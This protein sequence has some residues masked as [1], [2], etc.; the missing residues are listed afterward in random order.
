MTPTVVALA[1]ALV[2]ATGHGAT[3]EVSTTTYVQGRTAFLEGEERT[4][5]P[6]IEAIGLNATDVGNPLVG[7]L[8]MHLSAWGQVDPFLTLGPQG[9][10]ADLDFA[11]LAGELFNRHLSLK[12]GRHFAFGGA[13]RARQ[14]DGA[15]VELHLFRGLGLSAHGGLLVVPR[16]AMAKGD[17]VLGARLFY[18]ASIDA[19]VGLGFEQVWE[20]G[21]VAWQLAG[22]DGRYVW[23][24]LTFGGHAAWALDARRFAEGD[25]AITWQPS[26]KLQASV[27]VRRTAP[28][29]FLSRNSILSVFAA[30]TRDGYGADLDWRPVRLLRLQAGYHYLRFGAESGQAGA[31]LAGEAGHEAALRAAFNLQPGLTAGLQGRWLETPGNGYVEGRLFLTWAITESLALAVDADLYRFKEPIQGHTHSYTGSASLTWQMGPRWAACLTGLAT[32]TPYFES[33][34]EGL[35]RLVYNF[36]TRQR[37]EVP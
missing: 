21:D 2:T 23:R 5:I 16:F 30:Q 34:F 11:Y 28:D 33:R 17:A 13:A 9:N 18:R 10:T 8:S 12:L 25:L 26:A 37:E 20:R 15:S 4:V 6:V 22:I 14:V 36:S 27:D 1:S 31:D 35:A 29:L 7:D 19:E 3:V 24:T 32:Y